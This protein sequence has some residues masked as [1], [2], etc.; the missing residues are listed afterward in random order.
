VDRRAFHCS[1]LEPA[2]AGT[3]I[4]CPDVE[5][6]FM[7]QAKPKTNQSNGLGVRVFTPGRIARMLFFSTR[8]ITRACDRGDLP[9]HRIPGGKDR[10][11]L[12]ENLI[13][14][15]LDNK[16]PMP[17]EL[18]VGKRIAVGVQ[19]VERT[20]LGI[21][22]ECLTPIQAGV[23]CTNSPVEIALV[24]DEWGLGESVDLALSVRALQPLARVVL[25][26]SEESPTGIPRWSGEVIRRP[27]G[28]GQF[29]TTLA[30]GAA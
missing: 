27:G 19:P 5:G 23:T 3:L 12:R 18:R 29:L 25:F 11:I 24:G 6:A 1:I 9:C 21:G 13:R 7:P 26:V 15:I 14:F 10:Y 22:W 28:L 30:N 8:T 20:V 4:V 16:L 17:A 2:T